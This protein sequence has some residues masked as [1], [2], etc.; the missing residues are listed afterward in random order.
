LI[1]GENSEEQGLLF[2]SKN[3]KVCKSEKILDSLRDQYGDKVS[4]GSLMLRQKNN[5]DE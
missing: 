3:A 5:F 2:S 4:R 1:H